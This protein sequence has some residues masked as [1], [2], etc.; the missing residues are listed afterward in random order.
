VYVDIINKDFQ[1]L[2][3]P[4]FEYLNHHPWKKSITFFNLDGTTF[5]SQNLDLLMIPGFFISSGDLP[6]LGSKI[7]SNKPH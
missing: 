4:I 6:K 7:R 2:I 5:H 3:V 1:K